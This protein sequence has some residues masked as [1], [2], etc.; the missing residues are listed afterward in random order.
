MDNE[1]WKTINGFSNYEVS[2]LGR[3]RSKPRPKTKGGIM[4]QYLSSNQFHLEVN[5]FDDNHKHKN[6]RV[7]KLVAGHFLP[8][9]YGKP[10]ID[11]RNRNSTDNRVVN[12]RWCSSSEN[13]LNTKIRSDNTS[14]IKG[15]LFDKARNKWKGSIKFDGKVYSKRFNTKEEAIEYRNKLVEEFYD[16]KFYNN[17]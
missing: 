10:E 17:K 9:Y 16:D 8:N 7:H 3:V 5:L 4:K 11:H 12:L 15:V 13:K 14:G 1:N 2:D 6:M